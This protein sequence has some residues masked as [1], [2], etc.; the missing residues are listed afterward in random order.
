MSLRAALQHLE[1]G[2]WEKAHAIAQADESPLGAWVHAIV[3]IQ[4][5]DASNARYWFGQAGR[6]FSSDI[7][8]ELAAL[9]S[10]LKA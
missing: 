9:R 5:G 2:E 6:A 3:H 10:A 4:E 8:A 1:Q 7:A